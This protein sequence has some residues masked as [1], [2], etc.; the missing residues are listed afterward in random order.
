MVA[1]VTAQGVSGEVD[2]SILLSIIEALV[3]IAD[4]LLNFY[5]ARECSVTQDVV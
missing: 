2:W 3:L 5:D 1:E 4:V